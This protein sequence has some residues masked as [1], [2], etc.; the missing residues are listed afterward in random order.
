VKAVFHSRPG[1][2][3]AFAVVMEHGVHCD[4][5]LSGHRPCDPRARHRRV[6]G[7]RK[8]DF[9]TTS[10]TRMTDTGAGRAAFRTTDGQ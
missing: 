8:D 10:L 5:P 1:G 2:S 6:R 7:R 9:R 4:P 3:G